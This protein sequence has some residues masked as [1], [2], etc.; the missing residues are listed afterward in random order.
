VLPTDLFH[1]NSVGTVSGLGGTG[2]AIGTIIVFELAGHISD[3]RI[4]TGTHLFDPLMILSGLIPLTGMLLVLLLV[5]NTRA[6][7]DGLVRK[8]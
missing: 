2:A 8:I 4:A 7:N 1:T 6:T 5:R 3:A